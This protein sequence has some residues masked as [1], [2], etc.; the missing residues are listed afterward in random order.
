MTSFFP[1]H[2]SLGVGKTLCFRNKIWG[3]LNL[4]HC[5]LTLQQTR[6]LLSAIALDKRSLCTRQ[7]HCRVLHSVKSCRH[8]SSRQMLL[9]RVSHVGHSAKDFPSATTALG[10]EKP[11][12]RPG[13][14]DGPFAECHASALGKEMC[15][16]FFK[17]LCRV[18][19]SGTRQGL[20]SFFLDFL[21]RVL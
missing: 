15:F 12:W 20:F 6:G 2:T 1:P 16:L 21:C 7:S 9:C 18:P 17:M 3:T 10:K 4:W 11:P 13:H 19:A 5:H 8:I 14:G